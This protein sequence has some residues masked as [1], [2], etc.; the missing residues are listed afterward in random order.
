MFWQQVLPGASP[1]F[2]YPR[3]THLFVPYQHF[4]DSSKRR[5]PST[6]GRFRTTM[7]KLEDVFICGVLILEQALNPPTVPLGADMLQAW[8]FPA[9]HLLFLSDVV[10]CLQAPPSWGAQCQASV[11]TPVSSFS[12]P[13]SWRDQLSSVFSLLAEK[14]G[15]HYSISWVVLK[16]DLPSSL[17]VSE[18]NNILPPSFIAKRKTVSRGNLTED[19]PTCTW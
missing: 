16:V 9:A 13:W 14:R 5:F 6:G 4:V 2:Y 1:G 10:Q 7:N 17:I 18:D 11:P 15:R 19:L 8:N 12:D 3:A